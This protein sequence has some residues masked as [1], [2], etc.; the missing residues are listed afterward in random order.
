[1][2]EGCLHQYSFSFLCSYLA[3]TAR[4]FL[5]GPGHQTAYVGLFHRK[6]CRDF[7]IREALVPEEKATTHRLLDFVECAPDSFQLLLLFVLGMLDHLVRCFLISGVPCH[8]T[9]LATDG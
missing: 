2:L 8:R 6:R 4:E 7:A 9:A 5:A 3:V 1:M